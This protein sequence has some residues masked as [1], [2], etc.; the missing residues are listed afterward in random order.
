MRAPIS[1][2]LLI[3][4]GCNSGSGQ[5]EYKLDESGTDATVTEP[6]DDGTTG[7]TDT[8][9]E[10]E[11]G[12]WTG[13]SL[14]VESPAPGELL[15]YGEDSTFTAVVLDDS[16]NP[17]DFTDLTWTTNASN[18]TETGADFESDGLDVGTQAITVEA[19]L[20]DGT[21]LRNSVGG[22]RVQ[23]PDAGT[24][25]GNLAV[26]ISGE[27][28][29]FPITAACI[30]AAIVTVNVYGEQATGDSTCIVSLLGF[31]TQALHVFDFQVDDETVAGQVEL[32]LSFFQIGFEVEG[33]LQDEVMSAV[34]ATDYGGFLT[35]EGDME[36]ERVTTDTT[37]A[38]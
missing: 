34:W 9:E 12:D 3:L 7:T 22:V 30:G 1:G 15:P 5:V 21:V 28:N 20:P 33:E 23:H 10:E 24:Y 35:V 19:V 13:S 11:V 36:L 2:L 32:D 37:A 8:E 18:W 14:V 31:E 25:V 38:E 16:G 27:Y 29:G 17:T 6:T 26:D 4:A